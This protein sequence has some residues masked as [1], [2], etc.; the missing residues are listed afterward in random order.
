MEAPASFN[1]LSWLYCLRPGNKVGLNTVLYAL[2]PTR[3]QPRTKLSVHR[4]GLHNETSCHCHIG[5][6]SIFPVSLFSSLFFFCVERGTIIAVWPIRQRTRSYLKALQ[7]PS[8]K[9]QSGIRFKARLVWREHLGS[10]RCICK[11]PIRCTR[12]HGGTNRNPLPWSSRWDVCPP[13]SS[14]RLAAPWRC[15]WFPQGPPAPGGGGDTRLR[16]LTTAKQSDK[17]NPASLQ[18]WKWTFLYYI[19]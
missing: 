10:Q 7:R 17:N 16:P 1:F 9:P 14:R 19:T 6:D 15:W 2:L 18:S 12:M 5:A 8:Q 4:N 3:S 11:N 13:P